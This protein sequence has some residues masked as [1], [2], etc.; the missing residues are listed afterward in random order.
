MPGMDGFETAAL[1]RQRANSRDTPIIFITAFGD[2][3]HAAQ[4]YSLGAVDYILAPVLPEVLQTKVSVFVELFVKTEQIKRQ[5]QSLNRRAEQLQKLAEASLVIN[6]ALSTERMLAILADSAREIIGTHQ[7]ILLHLSEN[8]S[9][10]TTCSFSEKYVEW[11]NKGIQ[12]QAIAR[13]LVFP[14][15]SATRLTEEEIRQNPDLSAASGTQIPPA[16]GGILAAP[17]TGRDGEAIGVIYLSDRLDG[18]FTADDQAVLVQLAQMGSI[19]LENTV[20]AQE[21]HVNRIKDEFLAT[22][23]H[24]LRTPLNAILGWTQLLRMEKPNAEVDHGLEVIERNARAQ[25]KLIEDLLDVS[26][27]ETGKMRLNLTRTQLPPIVRSAIDTARPAADGKSITLDGQIQD[28]DLPIQ[29]DPDRILQAIGNLL[30]NAIKFTPQG[31]TVSLRLGEVSEPCPGIRLE[32]RDTGQGI[33]PKFIPY[34]FD[35]FRQGDSASTRSHGGLGIGLAIVRY[36]VQQHGGRVSAHSDGMG[37]GATFAI[38]LPAD[39]P[40]SQSSTAVAPPVNAS[41]NHLPQ[42]Q[43]VRALVV[44]DEPD[45]RELIATVLRQAG[46]VVKTADSVATALDHLRESTPDIL[47]SDIA[48]PVQD[49]YML[50]RQIRESSDPKQRDL[51][52]IALTAYAREEDK[53]RAIAA[54]FHSHLAK[55]IDPAELIARISQLAARN[56]GE[57]SAPDPQFAGST[58]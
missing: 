21:R 34:V 41:K 13:Q 25:T 56:N 53:R 26:R 22:L 43:G 58:T 30:S 37:R 27:I 24:E 20:Y 9:A 4:G 44:D 17:L 40:Q 28:L 45:A 29:A 32:I 46:A 33:D 57:H 6:S 1:I 39:T 2:E 50:V 49:G 51:P 36:V 54:G 10:K 7:A 15:R 3:M 18:E 31:G 52:A 12:L 19:A 16:R 47:V 55:P 14:G 8:A 11:Q 38:E 35:R 42:V 5:A 48:M 23:S